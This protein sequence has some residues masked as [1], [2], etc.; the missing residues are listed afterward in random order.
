M[1]KVFY[2]DI[3]RLRYKIEVQNNEEIKTILS[4]LIV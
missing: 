3:M 4:N 1:S 2:G